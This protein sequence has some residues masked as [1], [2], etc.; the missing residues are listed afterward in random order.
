MRMELAL[1]FLIAVGLAHT[2]AVAEEQTACGPL[3]VQFSVQAA[4]DHPS[5]HPSPGKAL[6][7]VV[8]DFRKAP[9]EL[10]NPTI[11]IGL[12]GK[13]MGALRAKSYLSFEVDP[14]E[15]H[16]CASWQSHLKR[17]SKLASFAHFSSEA[18]KT[19]Y[20]RARITYSSYGAG[21]ANMNLD[22]EPVDSDEGKFLIAT[23]AM[24]QSRS[25]R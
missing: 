2:S 22:L 20:F 18:D 4:G 11:R 6:V 15:R 25:N 10:G 1:L 17:L 21:A 24:S 23:K 5:E 16:L 19:Y 9:G 14:G 3:D 8:E 7:Y 12:D 13:W